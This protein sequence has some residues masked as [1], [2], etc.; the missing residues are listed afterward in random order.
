MNLLKM[1][2]IGTLDLLL[3]GTGL[4]AYSLYKRNKKTKP[5]RN[6]DPEGGDCMSSFGPGHIE[7]QGECKQ[8]PKVVQ[9]GGMPGPPMFID[10]VNYG[11]TKKATPF[12]RECSREGFTQF[13]NLPS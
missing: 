1:M 12:E 4:I 7:W 2:K 10:G 8:C 6:H 13:E 11:G 5:R 9:I 3:I